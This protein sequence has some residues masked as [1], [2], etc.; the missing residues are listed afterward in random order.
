MSYTNRH[1]LLRAG[2]AIGTGVTSPEK[3]SVGFRFAIIGADVPWSQS[4]LLAFATSCFGALATFHGSA[5]A[6]VGGQV[7]LMRTSAATIGVDGKYDPLTQETQFYEPAAV[8]GN[9]ATT[10]PWNTAVVTSLRTNR[11]RG[12]ASNGR[13]YYP[14]LSIPISSATGRLASGDVANRLALFRTLINTMNTHAETYQP[15]MRL[16]VCSAVGSGTT[17]LVSGIRIDDRLDSIER[18]ENAN[19]VVYQSLPIP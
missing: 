7:H 14:A 8:S 2:G 4:G 12:Y 19:P 10:L 1:V 13:T 9:G 5:N 11:P 16:A 6:K 17:A 3:W 18:R 15:N